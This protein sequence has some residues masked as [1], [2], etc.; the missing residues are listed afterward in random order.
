[1]TKTQS[2]NMIGIG[3]AMFI[4][5]GVA[6]ALIIAQGI[7]GIER[8]VILEWLSIYIAPVFAWVFATLFSLGAAAGLLV[9]AHETLY[10]IIR[11]SWMQNLLTVSAARRC[12]LQ[13]WIPRM[14]CC[15]RC[16]RK[17]V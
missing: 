9:I 8:D 4:I 17:D 6:A 10:Q 12:R 3:L 7:L 2:T 11:L 5:C 13:H 16:W 15:V 1:M 14:R